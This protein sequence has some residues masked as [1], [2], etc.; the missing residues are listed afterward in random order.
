MSRQAVPDQREPSQC[1]SKCPALKSVTAGPQFQVASHETQRGK[2]A[3]REGRGAGRQAGFST[4]QNSMLF[5]QRT[6][7]LL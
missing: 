2:E 5:V 1:G 4:S 3:G 6:Q 7:Q